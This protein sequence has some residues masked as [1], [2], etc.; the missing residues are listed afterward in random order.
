MALFSMVCKPYRAGKIVRT[1]SFANPLTNIVQVFDNPTESLL[2]LYGAMPGFGGLVVL[3]LAPYIADYLGRRNGTGEHAEGPPRPL[4]TFPAVRNGF[5][6]V[7]AL[8]QA[9]PQQEI[10]SQC[11]WLED[12]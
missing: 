5:V 2:G 7:G 3:L 10:Q 12:F 8:L 1:H 11:T 4:I 9:F 6:L